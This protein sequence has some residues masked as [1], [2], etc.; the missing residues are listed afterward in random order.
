MKRATNMRWIV[1]LCILLTA[2]SAFPVGPKRT[3]HNWEDEPIPMPTVATNVQATAP[4]VSS[5]TLPT[6]LTPNSTPSAPSEPAELSTPSQPSELRFDYPTPTAFDEKQVTEFGIQINGC[7]KDVPMALDIVQRMGLTWIKQQARWAD[8]ETGPNIFDWRCMDR[9]IP[10]A[11]AHG[12]KVLISVTTAPAHTRQIYKGILHPTNGRPMDFRDFGLFLARLIARYPKQIQALEL[13]NE[14]NLMREWGDVLDG[15]V[16]A[17]LLAA[18]YGAVKAIDPLIMVISAG[19]APTGMN[20]QWEAIDD[21]LFLKQFAANEG[22][23]YAD[24]IGAHANGPD[25]VGEIQ[26]VVPRQLK[27]LG[28]SRPA[29]VTELGYA[30]PIDGRAPEG[31][32]W[33]MS[34]TPERQT[35]VLL[36]GMRWARQSGVVRLVILWNLNFDG[37]VGDPNV[38]YALVREGFESPA[39]KTIQ[40]AMDFSP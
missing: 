10:I 7:D 13:W 36:G 30:L 38:P 21:V 12:L 20:S 4:T 24:C 40:A 2:C 33:I 3:F 27:T 29:C 22:P 1:A 25:G 35:E 15:G 17:Q 14:P 18:G 26:L 9:V 23:D 34:H 19:V 31:F 39:L 11:H 5:L 16:Y 8:I 32:G 37:P 28:H 6:P